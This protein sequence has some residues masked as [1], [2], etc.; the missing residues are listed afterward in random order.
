MRKVG[1]MI[2]VEWYSDIRISRVDYAEADAKA[3][4]IAF[5]QNGFNSKIGRAHV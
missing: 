3:L 4:S 2:A 1:L 5:H